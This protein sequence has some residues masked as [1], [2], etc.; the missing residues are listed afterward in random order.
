MTHLLR[1]LSVFQCHEGL[2]SN[3]H[4][5][6]RKQGN[7]TNSASTTSLEFGL[8]K[9]A[10]NCVGTQISP[11]LKPACLHQDWLWLYFGETEQSGFLETE[12]WL[13]WGTGCSPESSAGRE[14]SKVGNIWTEPA[15]GPLWLH[16]PS[17]HWKKETEKS[18]LSMSCQPFC[19]RAV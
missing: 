17:F 13:W 3:Q 5:G 1:L 19:S 6:S 8:W 14:S 18:F 4:T 11:C 16:R 10:A 7:T 2:E 12:H 9:R 15:S